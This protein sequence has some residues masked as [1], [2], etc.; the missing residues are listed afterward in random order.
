MVPPF[1][2]GGD[3]NVLDTPHG[4]F[5]MAQPA[6]IP[7]AMISG[8][9]SATP[10]EAS[11]HVDP[12]GNVIMLHQMNPQAFL[13]PMMYPAYV[14]ATN[15]HELGAYGAGTPPE[16]P[17][18]AQFAT[19]SWFNDPVPVGQSRNAALPMGGVGLLDAGP[20]VPSHS[21]NM[22]PEGVGMRVGGTSTHGGTG[23]SFPLTRRTRTGRRAPVRSPPRTMEAS[24]SVLCTRLLVEGADIQAVEFV[25]DVIFP[26]AVSEE[27]LLAP[28]NTHEHWS[29]YGGATKVWQLL[30]ETKEAIPGEKSYCCR[31]CPQAHRP[32]YK[33]GRDAVRHFKKDHF[34]FAVTCIYW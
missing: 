24:V 17:V 22:P 20:M 11:I 18:F 29:K 3:E 34:G 21:G 32:E 14:D 5:G 25:R 12:H 15:R 4:V 1:S 9:S 19:P 16:Q 33:Y 31:L 2:A 10:L 6:Y 27:A 8:V 7:S 26:S 30:L 28:I 23:I 13:V